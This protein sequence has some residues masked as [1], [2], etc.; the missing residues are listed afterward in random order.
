[1]M[2]DQIISELY[3]TLINYSP[4][5]NRERKKRREKRK[6]RHSSYHHYS[7]PSPSGGLRAADKGTLDERDFKA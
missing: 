3:T 5:T 2:H 7:S 6:K 1:M 4:A